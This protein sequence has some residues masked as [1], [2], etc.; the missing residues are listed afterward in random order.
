MAAPG[1]A[2]EASDLAA[3]AAEAVVTRF[4]VAAGKR[5]IHQRERER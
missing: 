5:Q 3:A 2:A 1:L 4:R